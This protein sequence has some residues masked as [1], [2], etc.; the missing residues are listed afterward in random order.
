MRLASGNPVEEGTRIRDVAQPHRY[1][2][3]REAL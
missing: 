2:A 3:I 1:L